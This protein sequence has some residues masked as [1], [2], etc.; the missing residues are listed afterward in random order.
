M[1]NPKFLLAHS[2]NG[3]RS[4]ELPDDRH[5]GSYTEFP[6]VRHRM[7]ATCPDLRARCISTVAGSSPYLREHVRC[8]YCTD[9]LT[10]NVP[11]V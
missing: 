11:G 5:Q 9:L 4:A 1:L 8:E 3:L 7:Q 2:N 10:R 6:V